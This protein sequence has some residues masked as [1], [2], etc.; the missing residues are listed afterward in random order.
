MARSVAMTEGNPGVDTE[1]SRSMVP[2][3]VAVA[4]G[5]LIIDVLIGYTAEGPL[6]ALLG[7]GGFV[8]AIATL[9]N[10]AAVARARRPQ[11]RAFDVADGRFLP[12][13]AEA[14]G[15]F[16][17]GESLLT[18]VVAVSPSAG[19]GGVLAG[20]EP[21]SGR[22]AGRTAS[23]SPSSSPAS[24][25]GTRCGGATGSGWPWPPISRGSTRDSWPR[26]SPTTSHIRSSVPASVRPRGT[27]SCARRSATLIDP[28]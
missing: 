16:V 11:R 10:L 20:W 4:A 8:L 5:W 28:C 15:F 17:A 19:G 6:A 18:G 24:S 23:F 26:R 2:T 22:P 25:T 12:P 9:W 14:S 3:A 21:G 13:P 27:T 1:P 7:L